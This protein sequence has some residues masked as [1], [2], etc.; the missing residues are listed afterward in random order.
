MPVKF[1]RQC[2]RCAGLTSQK[3]GHT[4]RHL[5]RSAAEIKFMKSLENFIHGN[6]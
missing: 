4:M 2:E 6:C 5:W 1:P 3:Q